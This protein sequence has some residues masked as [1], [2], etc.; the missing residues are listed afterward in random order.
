LAIV[1][2]ATRGLGYETALALAQAG[3]DVIVAGRNQTSGHEALGRIRPQAPAA[4]VRFER[5]DLASLSS[6]ADFAGRVADSGRPVDLLINNAS[7]PAMPRRQVTVDGFEMQLGTNYLGHYALTARLLPLLRKGHRPRVVQLT[8]AAHDQGEI[9]FDDL[10][11]ER[12]Y[13]PWQAHCQSKLAMLLFALELQ[14]Q[15]DAHRWGLLSTASQPENASRE[16]F[17]HRQ[18]SK[19]AFAWFRRLLRIRRS[20]SETGALPT[21]FAAISRN[22]QPAGY[23]GPETQSGLI[24]PPGAVATG[25][26]ARDWIAAHKLWEMSAQLTGV[27]WPSA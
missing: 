17:A 25:E 9:H 11:L 7:L 24:G 8:S 19:D 22:V 18:E 23:Y 20:D 15:S 2:G 1:T 26:G 10:Q 16:Y 21:L 13:T 6:V 27:E 4:L 3:A 5:L 12:G 14:R